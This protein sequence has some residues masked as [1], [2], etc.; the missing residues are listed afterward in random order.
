[1][2]AADEEDK[3]NYRSCNELNEF[4]SACDVSIPN[5]RICLKSIWLGLTEYIYKCLTW[6]VHFL[7]LCHLNFKRTADSFNSHLA[8]CIEISFLNSKWE[9][10]A[11]KSK[12]SLIY[13]LRLLLSMVVACPWNRGDSRGRGKMTRMLKMLQ[14][15]PPTNHLLW[16]LTLKAFWDLMRERVFYY[17]QTLIKILLF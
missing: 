8:A 7:Q 5:Y 16:S 11:I 14:S 9:R 1:M 3:K 12:M 6:L 4:S 10:N 15:N 13:L 2:I 17:V